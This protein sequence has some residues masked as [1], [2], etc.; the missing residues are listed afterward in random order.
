MLL[1]TTWIKLLEFVVIVNMIVTFCQQITFVDN[2]MWPN[3]AQS[4]LAYLSHKNIIRN[5]ELVC[6]KRCISYF[7]QLC[8]FCSPYQLECFIL[9]WTIFIRDIPIEKR[10][11]SKICLFVITYI[12]AYFFYRYSRT[13][14]FPQMTCKLFAVFFLSLHEKICH[15]C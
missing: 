1:G 3:I 5:S 15:P 11:R 12:Y 9:K 2:Q 6:S 8:Y 14:I 10:V 13:V 7:L 4:F